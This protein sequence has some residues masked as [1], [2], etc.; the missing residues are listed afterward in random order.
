MQGRWVR[1][2]AGY[3]GKQQRDRV[4]MVDLRRKVSKLAQ[5]NTALARDQHVC[6]TSE[7]QSVVVYSKQTNK[8]SKQQ[9][10]IS[11]A[12]KLRIKTAHQ[13]SATAHLPACSEPCP[14]RFPPSNERYRQYQ[15][16]SRLHA[17]PFLVPGQARWPPSEC[18][19]LLLLLRACYRQLLQRWRP[20]RRCRC[21]HCRRCRWR[22]Q[23][24][25]HAGVRQR[26]LQAS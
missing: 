10:L 15:Q 5:T 12:S 6:K 8:Q 21:P 13:R 3:E 20:R 7:R 19:L 14:A 23:D 25:P 1:R 11:S 17:R 22:Q 9:Q 16:R 24:M 2:R 26:G 4:S 18:L